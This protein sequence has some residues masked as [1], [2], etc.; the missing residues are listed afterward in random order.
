V[1][2]KYLIV[3][4]PFPGNEEHLARLKDLIRELQLEKDVLLTGEL[5]D[6]RGAYAAM[7]VFTLTSAQPEPFGGVVLEAMASER[8]VIA[9]NI[10]GSPD[11][12][13]EGVTGFLVPPNDPEALA[14]K[15]QLLLAD[16]ELLKKMGKAGR[17]RVMTE[18]PVERMVRETE[19]VY[20]ELL[21]RKK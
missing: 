17:E 12:V 11:Q 20:A 3:G 16:S 14:D 9:T 6:V 7:N 19:A 8:P 1:R 18:F 21:A 4:A 5:K 13:V 2:A 10:G 15:I